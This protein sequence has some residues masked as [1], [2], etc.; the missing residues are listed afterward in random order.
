MDLS[1]AHDVVKILYKL[2]MAKVSNNLTIGSGKPTTI[3]DI[4]NS[5]S[6]ISGVNIDITKKNQF[7]DDAYNNNCPL[8][9]NEYNSFIEYSP[10]RSVAS[11][12]REIY[13][14]Y[15]FSK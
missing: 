5:F 13:N 9:A 1:S 11:V 7:E 14:Y 15:L 4:V 10:R 2:V 12:C 8:A 3:R 6:I